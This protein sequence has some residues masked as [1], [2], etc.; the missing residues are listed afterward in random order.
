[1]NEPANPLLTPNIACIDPAQ[2][3]CTLVSTYGYHSDVWELTPVRLKP[4][5]RRRPKLVKRHLRA[6]S[7]REIRVLR[8]DYQKLKRR[9]GTMVPN[10]V[11]VSTRVNGRDNVIVIANK[12]SVW[13][14]IANPINEQESIPFFQRNNRAREDL[15]KFVTAAREWQ[16]DGRIIDLWGLDNLVLDQ[17]YKLRYLDSFWVFL[18]NDLQHMVGDIDGSLNERIEISL[19]RLE[20]L[21]YVLQQVDSA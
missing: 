10:A 21:E 2:Y 7:F 1:M 16:S 14:N 11:F 12:I 18:Y 4:D 19:R 9:F 3:I 5:R 20:Y 15:R 17:R 6:C 13:F 8:R